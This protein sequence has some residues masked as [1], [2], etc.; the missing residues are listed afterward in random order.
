MQREL[1]ATSLVPLEALDPSNI[2]AG[3]PRA[4][5]TALAAIAGAEV[6]VWV[7]TEGTVVD[8][9]VDEIFVVLEGTATVEFD[10]GE[11]IELSPGSTVRL[12]AGDKTTWTVRSTLRKVY[13]VGMGL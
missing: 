6:G 10:D 8:V 2:V 13:F 5:S 11:V 9:E 3:E 7:M 1:D 4:G 12:R